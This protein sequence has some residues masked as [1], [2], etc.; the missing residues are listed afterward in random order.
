MT[1]TP[2][3]SNA[4][5][6]QRPSGSVLQARHVARA[7]RAADSDGDVVVRQRR[8]VGRAV[9]AVQGGG[10]RRGP[11]LEV[12][13]DIDP[14]GDVVQHVRLLYS[15]SA[16]APRSK[17]WE[18]RTGT[19]VERV[20]HAAQRALVP[21]AGRD[22]EADGDI[23]HG[24]DVVLGDDDGVETVARADGGGDGDADDAGGR[25]AGE[26]SGRGE[27][28]GEAHVGSE[29]GSFG[30]G[31]GGVGGSG[32]ERAIGFDWWIRWMLN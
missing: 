24:L 6:A 16:I 8:A 7:R 21:G 15:S 14:F 3:R 25:E 13:G 31:D 23:E 1:I 9:Q 5:Q 19:E 26:A 30:F 28:G 4:S 22:A 12:G 18:E 2:S 20:E 32:K 17:R 10:E 27:D 11:L 29:A